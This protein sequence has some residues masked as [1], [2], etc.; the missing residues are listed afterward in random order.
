MGWVH[1]RVLDLPCQFLAGGVERAGCSHRSEEGAHR[2]FRHRRPDRPPHALE[3]VLPHY[4]DAR[5][6]Q[7]LRAE[8]LRPYRQPGQ[9]TRKSQGQLLGRPQAGSGCR[10]VAGQVR[11]ENRQLVGSLGAVDTQ[12]QRQIAPRLPGARQQAPSGA[13]RGTG[14]VRAREGLRA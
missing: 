13:G 2:D 4:P 5:R 6:A 14:A 7:H 10:A 3:G 1:W 11:E 12:A 9:P 8:Q